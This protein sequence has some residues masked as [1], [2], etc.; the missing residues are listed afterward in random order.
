MTMAEGRRKTR[1][2]SLVTKSNSRVLQAVF[3]LKHENESTVGKKSRAKRA[4]EIVR[5]LDLFPYEEPVR[6]VKSFKSGVLSIILV[7]AF[8]Y[9][10]IPEFVALS[11]GVPQVSVD[12]DSSAVTFAA[13]PI[14]VP[15]LFFT[16]CYGSSC[17]IGKAPYFHNMSYYRI[18]AKLKS[19]FESGSNPNKPRVEVEIPVRMCHLSFDQFGKTRS[20]AGWCID[21]TEE[22][23]IVGKYSDVLY[24]YIEISIVPCYAYKDLSA[25]GI[26]TA[27]AKQNRK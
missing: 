3:E 18:E 17:A 10:A 13:N 2:Q 8:V 9:S 19:I 12:T 11:Q 26:Q 5:S 16:T 4:R 7:L 27:K 21:T 24:R 1:R 23:T 6:T 20:R 25:S 22:H 14:A 15:H